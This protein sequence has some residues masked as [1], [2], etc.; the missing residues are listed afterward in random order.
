MICILLKAA[1]A[2]TWRRLSVGEWR[3]AGFGYTG[4]VSAGVDFIGR[5]R[6][7]RSAL[8]H[9]RRGRRASLSVRRH[10]AGVGALRRAGDPVV[11]GLVVAEVLRRGLRADGLFF[12]L[13]DPRR[14]PGRHEEEA[15]K[16]GRG[17]DPEGGDG[18]GE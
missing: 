10:L 5:P 4:I 13:L 3:R 12:R 1:A 14:R 7:A 9:I 16:R 8:G 18:P 17:G 15:G 2:G 11:E 6:R